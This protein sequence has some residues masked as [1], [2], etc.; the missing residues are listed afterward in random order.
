MRTSVWKVGGSSFDLPDLAPRLQALL[1][2][3]RDSRVLL[4]PGGGAAADIVRQ[5][6]P[7]HALDDETAHC[8]AMF[9]MD[10]NAGLLAALVDRSELVDSRDGAD[11][12]WQRGR[13]PVLALGA[14]ACRPGPGPQA[15]ALDLPHDWTVTSDSLAA[16]VAIAWAADELVLLK[17]R[18]LEPGVAAVSAAR[19]GWVDEFF[20]QIV[21]PVPQV[22]WCNLRAEAPVIQDWLT[23][24]VPVRAP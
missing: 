17:S 12:C 10:F 9:A 20:P 18:P 8:L 21:G 2:Q 24:G 7:R 22:R 14:G 11:D 6:Q 15:P 1:D 23:A 13:T 16:W 4:I 5:W 3:S 19:R